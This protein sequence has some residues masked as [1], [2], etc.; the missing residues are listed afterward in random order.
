[1]VNG[2]HSIVSVTGP[3][4]IF[5]V[6]PQA[7]AKMPIG[8]MW[9]VLFFFMLLC[10]GLNSQVKIKKKIS[11]MNSSNEPKIF[12]ANFQFAIVEVVVTSIQDGFPN[13]IKNKLVYHELLVLIV[14]VISFFCGLPNIIQGGIYF[15]QLIDHYA[16][17]ISIM[18]LAFF[19][20]IAITWFYGVRRLS[21]NIKQMTG[22]GPS[23]YFRSCWLVAGPLLLIV[24]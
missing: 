1:M 14:C 5:V 12:S 18:F 17:S 7:M 23:L 21:K 15:F 13:W 9:A 19:Q 6:Y 11:L 3:G 24:N 20:M 2:I 8:Q 4:L 16:A 22:K 10:L